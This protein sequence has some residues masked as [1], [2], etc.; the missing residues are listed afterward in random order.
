M[1][2]GV[3]KGIGIPFISSILI[4]NNPSPPLRAFGVNPPS[5][6]LAL[7]ASGVASLGAL[8]GTGLLL[9][10][11]I[12]QK[13]FPAAERAQFAIEI[14]LP[15]GTRLEA[16]DAVARKVEQSLAGDRRI[17]AYATFVGT[18]APRV[19]YSFAPEFPRPSYAMLLV[20]T[21]SVAA[22][23]EAVRDYTR[24]L[25]GLHPNARMNVTSFQQGIPTE[26]PVEIRIVGPELQVLRTESEF[27]RKLLLGVP[28]ATQVR[29]DFRDGFTL[30]LNVNSEVANRLGLATNVIASE[31]MAG[32]QGLP[33]TE[34][35]EHDAP[36][37][38][39]LRLNPER[40]SSFDDLDRFML[41]AP[42]TQAT[43][44]LKEVVSVEPVW[45]PAQISRRNGERTLTV[46]ANAAPG[47]LPSQILSKIRPQLALRRLPPGYHFE[48]GGEYEG[49]QETF[50]KM[51]GALIASVVAIYLVLLFQFGGTR[52][53]LL[54]ML[55]I[56]LT[57]FGAMAGL[58]ITGNPL[59]FTASVGLISLVG[60]VIRNSIILVD[61][62]D[63]LRRT[64]GL[65]A[66]TAAIRSGERRMRPIFLTS[67]A[68]AV[69]VLPMIISGSPLWAPL[70]SVFSIGI[71]W[72]MVMTL[73]V[74]PA[75]YALAMRN[76]PAVPA[77]PASS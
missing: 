2:P 57:F 8:R 53:T 58:L 30:D 28:G 71:L 61:F 31:V 19:Y 36:V 9:L 13:F 3:P 29:D 34:L 50:G 55:A 35:W 74:I 56:P 7:R 43:V 41:R 20:S 72:S 17:T 37:P 52:E 6:L 47:V 49:Q 68:A 75:A 27:F 10:P 64:E 77:K 45:N 51:A 67:M 70:A 76:V 59:G 63:E 46:R 21:T 12:S 39:V 4:S 16:T 66:T 11:G 65:D 1:F 48:I 25:A 14:D 23:D 5:L 62:A 22:A 33:L 42:L 54:V 26:A 24:K 15:L 40:R 73:L 18:A 60:I 32:F 38:I 44:A 69:G